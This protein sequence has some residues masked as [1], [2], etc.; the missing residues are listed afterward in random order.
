MSHRNQREAKLRRVQ[1]MGFMVY[2]LRLF[3]NTHPQSAEALSALQRYIALEREARQEYE[4][5]YGPLT[6]EAVEHSCRYDW[7]DRPW[8][9]EL[10]A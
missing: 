6:L 10:E 1:Q 9:W 2:E 8:P 5:A 3:L 4:Q 7:V